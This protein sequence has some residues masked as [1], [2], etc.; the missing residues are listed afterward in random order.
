MI[1]YGIMIQARNPRLKNAKKKQ[2]DVN[3][4]DALRFHST[5][6]GV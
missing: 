5:H 1:E 2:A 3:L 4:C 6:G